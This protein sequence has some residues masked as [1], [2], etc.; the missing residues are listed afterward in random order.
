MKLRRFNYQ[1]EI[2]SKSLGITTSIAK[3]WD[4]L[5]TMCWC[6]ISMPPTTPGAVERRVSMLQTWGR[7]GGQVPPRR[8]NRCLHLPAYLEKNSPKIGYPSLP[9]PP[10]FQQIPSSLVFWGSEKK[11]AQK[12]HLL[13]CEFHKGHSATLGQEQLA[14]DLRVHT[15][16]YMI[17]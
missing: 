10:V 4:I 1:G 6:I 9:N 14:G 17:W 13:T 8:P 12:K 5:L 11:R 7:F 16:R 2:M 3:S 15:V